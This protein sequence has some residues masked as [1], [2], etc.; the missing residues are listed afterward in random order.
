MKIRAV[1]EINSIK[2][3]MYLLENGNAR[4]SELLSDLIPSRSTLALT[5]RCLQDDQLIERNVKASRPV[6][7]WYTLTS[8]GREVA[9]HLSAIKKLV[10]R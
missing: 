7:T 9:E 3:L 8:T 10:S 1:L 5:L 6:Q 4:Y 2:V